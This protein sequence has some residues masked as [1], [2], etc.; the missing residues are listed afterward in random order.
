RRQRQV[1]VMLRR[2]CFP[3]FVLLLSAVPAGAQTADPDT[4][5]VTLGP[6]GIT[7]SLQLRDVGRDPNVFNER[8]DPRSDFTLTVVPRFEIIVK[9]KAMRLTFN[10]ATEYVYYQT[11]DTERSIN[12]SGAVR[13]DFLLSRVQ[14]YVLASGTSTTA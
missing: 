9:P 7:P 6:F 3:V 4:S 14:P 13:A 11:Y 2:V 10:S 1:P 8:D 12:R 5:T